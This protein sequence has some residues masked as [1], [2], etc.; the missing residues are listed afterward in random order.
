MIRWTHNK[1]INIK[2]RLTRIQ[3]LNNIQ[4]NV[5]EYFFRYG[6]REDIELLFLI[7]ICESCIKKDQGNRTF[8][9]LD[10]NDEMLKQNRESNGFFLTD[11]FKKYSKCPNKV[12]CNIYSLG[13]PDLH[14]ML[15]LLKQ[16]NKKFKLN[17]QIL[18]NIYAFLS[19]EFVHFSNSVSQLRTTPLKIITDNG[20]KHLGTCWIAV[21]Y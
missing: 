4:D 21:S 5:I 6:K 9:K 13:F 2:D 12:Q 10:I 7:P 14:C 11:F 8:Y 19:M 1:D 18:D 20:K 17:F 3:E 15:E 16:T